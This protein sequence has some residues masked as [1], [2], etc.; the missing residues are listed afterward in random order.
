VDLARG[1]IRRIPNKTAK[2][3]KPVVVGI[4]PALHERLS[5][6]KG[7]T[8]YVLPDMAERY[9]RDVALVTNAVK[10]HVLDCGIDVH[11]PGTGER[12]K[13]KKD[14]TP[15]RDKKTGR[16]IVENT[17]KPAIVEVGFH[18][19]RHTWVSLHA[20]RG[21]PQ[22]V[23]QA[24]VGHANP[25]MTRHYTHISD[26]TAREVALAL[27][28]FAGNGKPSAI[29][30]KVAVVC[31][32][33]TAWGETASTPSPLPAWAEQALMSMTATNWKDVRKEMLRQ[34]AP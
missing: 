30:S 25:A 19:L 33:P 14:G 13:R 3:G 29:P 16:V 21:T 15:E 34:R 8:G 18:S 5:A 26:E 23:I 12:I 27:P 24:S 32:T 31:E 7:R 10:A 17:D 1:I 4:P 11:A 22:A 6:V 20:E 28:V 2:S 9:Q